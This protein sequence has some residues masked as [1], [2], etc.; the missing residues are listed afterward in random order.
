MD[1]EK[2]VNWLIVDKKLSK[3]S[4]KDVYSRLKRILKLSNESDITKVK[5]EELIQSPVFLQ[6]SM[7]VKSQLK[8]AF[9][10]YLE[11]GEKK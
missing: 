2:F 9:S 6:Q 1:I 7:F 4:A 10:L 11:Y 8:R 5:Y 3:R